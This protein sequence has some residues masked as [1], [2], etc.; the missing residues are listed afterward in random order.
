MEIVPT[1]TLRMRVPEEQ[2]GMV[3][4][5]QGVGL[6]RLRE[7]T[8]V[9]SLTVERNS[10]GGQRLVEVTGTQEQVQLAQE[11]VQQMLQ[12]G[13]VQTG[14]GDGAP[15]TPQLPAG[16][17]APPQVPMPM[18]PGALATSYAPPPM[19]AEAMAAA[20]SGRLVGGVLH[21]GKVSTSVRVEAKLL[22]DADRI[23]YVVGRGGTGLKTLR[24]A[25]GVVIEMPRD[26]VLGR[27]LMCVRAPLDGLR[28]CI[29]LVC[30]KLLDDST[31]AASL[32]GLAGY[33][34][35]P[36]SVSLRMLIKSGTAGRV[37]GRE[38]A[39]LRSLR[40]LGVSVDLPREEH[41]PGERVCTI[42]GPPLAVA[43]AVASVC[44][45]Q[46]S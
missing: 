1:I 3:I 21:P 14:G 11:V 5:S 43:Q 37:I 16:A 38:G 8:G 34:G 24:E 28:G 7:E 46:V 29:A 17:Y 20:A 15:A 30:S 23:G 42:N 2:I 35:T 10:R 13:A 27:R 31:A 12:G 33:D 26:E 25:T 36:Q 45:A 41:L 4:G 40:A 19:V 18:M 39:G 32:A 6:K 22:L 44:E 9:G